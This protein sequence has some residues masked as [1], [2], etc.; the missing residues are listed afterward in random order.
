MAQGIAGALGYC[1]VYARAFFAMSEGSADRGDRPH[2]LYAVYDLTIGCPTSLDV[3]LSRP[4]A[5]PS[6]HMPASVLGICIQLPP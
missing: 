6:A 5:S 2:L 4:M 1:G 3:A